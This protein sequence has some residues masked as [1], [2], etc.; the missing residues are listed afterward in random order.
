MTR[1]SS[2]AALAALA[3]A[4]YA[5][6][7]PKVQ[8]NILTAIAAAGNGTGA[9]DY[10]KFVNP[11]VGTGECGRHTRHKTLSAESPFSPDDYG[12]VW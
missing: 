2:I 9:L 6:P 10:T 1:L 4:V 7:S 8:Q 11:F 5:Q 12:D 3:A